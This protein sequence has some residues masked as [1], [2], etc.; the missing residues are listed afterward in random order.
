[1]EPWR[2]RLELE[3]D[4]GTPNDQA[5]SFSA[6]GGGRSFPA[7]RAG[8]S[9]GSQRQVAGSSGGMSGHEWEVTVQE[10][11]R[12]RGGV[13]RSAAVIVGLRL[14]SDD[15]L[16]LNLTESLVE[17]LAAVVHAQQRRQGTLGGVWA[18]GGSDDERFSLH[19]LR[20]E[21]G[22][23]ITCSAHCDDAG[24]SSSFDGQVSIDGTV[25]VQVPV[26]EEAP[27]PL[28]TGT[29]T[30]RA[31]GSGSLASG[32]INDMVE[33]AEEVATRSEQE[34]STAHRCLQ[35]TI[36]RLHSAS[37][38]S[39]D[40]GL[41]S[42]TR[43]SGSSAGGGGKVSGRRKG[44]PVREVVLAHEEG[45][46]QGVICS[47]TTQT[48]WR[49][50]RPI[51][52]DVLGQRLVTMVASRSTGSFSNAVGT[53]ESSDRGTWGPG[54][55]AATYASTSVQGARTVKLVAEV[56]SHHGVKVHGLS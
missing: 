19:W 27:M 44:R 20:N 4:V 1:M 8:D 47:P 3:T 30:S 15:I 52:V 2:A 55:R 12:A 42:G 13:D 51:D 53:A 17:N 14:V 45:H 6:G 11:R 22:L 41:W 23:P 5:C 9:R 16:N 7:G 40:S 48:S 33:T 18:G 49:S 10:E 24:Y 31:R 28:L 37:R 21:T 29:F 34:Q 35:E 39:F 43:R 54:T 46:R 26:G 38:A 25:P 32:V 56:E 36:G 50:L